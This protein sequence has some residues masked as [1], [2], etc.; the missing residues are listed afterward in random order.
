M[1]QVRALSTFL[2]AGA[3]ALRILRKEHP[4]TR[5]TPRS[6]AVRDGRGRDDPG[7]QA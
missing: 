6:E 1:L 3:D 4:A 5:R 2:V 7:G